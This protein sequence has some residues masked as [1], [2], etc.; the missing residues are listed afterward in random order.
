MEPGIENFKDAQSRVAQEIKRLR[1]QIRYNNASVLAGWIELLLTADPNKYNQ[2]ICQATIKVIKLQ[3]KTPGIFGTSDLA[4]ANPQALLALLNVIDST[5]CYNEMTL[6]D[7]NLIVDHFL[8]IY[9]NPKFYY[10]LFQK[11]P[12]NASFGANWV[13]QALIKA[14]QLTG[15]KRAK[16]FVDNKMVPIL[17]EALQAK[18]SITQEA[19]AAHALLVA[20]KQIDRQALL[21][22]WDRLQKK[23]GLGGFRYYENQP[24]YRTDVTSHVGEVLLKF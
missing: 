9:T 13:T 17:K 15:N 20:N 19:I 23:W 2:E 18:R 14:Y 16:R 6:E 7:I 11:D 3:A 21:S 8:Q 22:R 5:N 10:E 1:P 12:K 24:W 4:F